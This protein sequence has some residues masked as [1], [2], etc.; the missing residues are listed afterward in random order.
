MT[1]PIVI[2]PGTT[3]TVSV[4]YEL[5]VNGDSVV[6]GVNTQIVQAESAPLTAWRVTSA[7]ADQD[8]KEIQ[9]NVGVTE[10]GLVGNLTL[11]AIKNAVKPVIK[12]VVNKLI[13][14]AFTNTVSGSTTASFVAMRKDVPGL[15]VRRAFNTGIPSNISQ[16]EASGDA[17]AGVVTF[18]SVK[19]DYKNVGADNDKITSLAKSLPAGTYLTAWHEPENDMTAAQYVAMFKNFYKVAK[20][21]NSTIYVGNVYM[22]Y[23]WGAGRNVKNGDDW[24]VGTDSTDFLAT[25]TYMDTWQKDSSGNPKTLA[26]DPDHLR[27][28]NWAVT[29]NKPLLLTESGVG[30][31]FTDT[32]RASYYTDNANWLI[33]KGYRMFL[34]W[35]GAG[36]PPNGESWDFYGGAAKWPLTLAAIQ[37]IAKNGQSDAKL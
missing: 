2:K 37:N 10:D 21:A 7:T 1:D 20:T 4:P 5:T 6:A 31:G 14:G 25:D 34:P 19:P 24:W 9:R 12:P 18:L 17:A 11:A 8:I 30:Q 32:Q 23:Q 33:S 27:W 13:V 16:T 22:T 29:K 35:N 28:H 15:L 36:T 3:T 26:N